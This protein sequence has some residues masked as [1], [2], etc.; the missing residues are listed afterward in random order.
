MHS[1]LFSIC[2]K[3]FLGFILKIPCK[4]LIDNLLQCNP[5][6]GFCDFLRPFVSKR[7]ELK[8]R[9]FCVTKNL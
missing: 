6:R 4:C 8:G 1:K 3:L 9:F 5:F 7:A 2:F